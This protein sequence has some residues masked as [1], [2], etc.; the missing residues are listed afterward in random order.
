MLRFLLDE[1]LRGPLWSAILRHNE[2]GGLPID[3]ERVGDP[4]DLPLGIDDATILIWAEREGRILLT[5]DVHTMPGHLRQQLL[6]GKHSRGI[7]VISIGFSIKELVIWLELV[8]H[9]GEPSDN[10]D[11]LIYVP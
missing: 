10:L 1:H 5:E 11:T 4:S 8:A 6:A 9:A 2:R 3:A 7:L